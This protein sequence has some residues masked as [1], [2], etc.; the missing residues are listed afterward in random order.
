VR[1]GLVVQCL[2]IAVAL[3]TLGTGCRALVL[4]GGFDANAIVFVEGELQ[5]TE[6]TAL[7]EVAHACRLA[8]ETLGYDE[9]MTHRDEEE[10]RW[11]AQTAGGDP[12]E[13][14]LMPKSGKR[15]TLR[16]RVGVIGDEA[17]SRLVLEQIRQSLLGIAAT[18]P[19]QVGGE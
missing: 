9:V 19:Q 13:I 11:Q 8:I 5:S 1:S 18:V 17:R 3:A 12:V 6:P 4:V 15:T 10:V 2:A 16:I 7:A 14:R